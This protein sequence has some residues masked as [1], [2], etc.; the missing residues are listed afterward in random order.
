MRVGKTAQLMGRVKHDVI[1]WE[2][3]GRGSLHTHV[4]FWIHPDD[5]ELISDQISAAV[6]ADW[7]DVKN[8]WIEPED[9][10][11]ARLFNIV[12]HKLQHKCR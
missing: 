1:R 11:E 4:L 12:W 5:V 10:A 2:V 6:P 3:Q 8:C 9:E 7:D